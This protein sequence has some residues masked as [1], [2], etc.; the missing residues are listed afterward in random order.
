[1][2]SSA[3]AQ[4]GIPAIIAEAGGRGQLEESAVQL[5]VDGVRNVCRLLG[6]LPG[7]PDPPRVAQRLV[8]SFVWLRSAHEGWWDAAVAAGDEVAAGALLGR[9]R[10]LWGDPLEE[11]EAP[12][13]GV[14]LFITTSP[15]VAADGLLLGLGTD[16][17]PI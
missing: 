13:D 4:A 11:I 2:T 10:N 3:A 6:M 1:M 14:I 17:M 15:A 8:G 9:V 7:D 12:K 16:L 5:L